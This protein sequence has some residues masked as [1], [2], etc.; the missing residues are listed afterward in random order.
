MR[1][2]TICDITRRP[3]RLDHSMTAASSFRVVEKLAKRLLRF[4]FS[5]GNEL[6]AW[7]TQLLELQQSIQ[8]K[9]SNEQDKLRSERDAAELASLR[10]CRWHA[11]HLGDAWAWLM[12]GADR[13]VLHPLGENSPVPIP[14]EHYGTK[15]AQV[16]AEGLATRGWG[17]PV[18]HDVT[19]CLRIGDI[20]FVRPD[21]VP[22]NVTVEVKT[23]YVGEGVGPDGTTVGE[24]EAT[25]MSQADIDPETGNVVRNVNLSRRPK[26]VGS[27]RV[28]RQVE[29]MRQAALKSSA[30]ADGLIEG[31]DTPVYNL[32]LESKSLDHMKV[33]RALIREAR[34]AGVAQRC[35]DDAFYYLV[36]YSPDGVSSADVTGWDLTALQDS[37]F[38]R[39]SDPLESSVVVHTIPVQDRRSAIT[40]VPY[41]LWSVPRRAVLDVLQG[42]LMI[43]V[44]VNQGKVCDRLRAEGLQLRVDPQQGGPGS[45]VV[46]M[47]G[48]VDGVAMKAEY[49]GVNYHLRDVV[50]EFESLDRLVEIV[51]GSV[52]T[53]S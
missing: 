51:H 19:D 43:T 26:P 20:T 27:R 48:E 3:M 16:L 13:Q 6:F 31:L 5:S 34:S 14:E 24:Y 9:I 37:S 18:L 47:R 40:V 36:M 42:R 4:E 22:R 44:L 28:D 41:F 25:V 1:R 39:C 12:L 53:V 49:H 32:R 38:L 21:R 45:V 30:P 10:S 29:R 50:E 8:A 52:A 15:G 46:E 11:R 33:L 2:P 7:Q 17:F 35:V 23:R